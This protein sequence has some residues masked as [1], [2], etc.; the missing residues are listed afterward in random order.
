[1]EEEY[2]SI[3]PE[4]PMSV[5]SVVYYR[6]VSMTITKRDSTIKIKP[7]IESQ[8]EMIDWA[9]DQKDCKPSWNEETNK[10]YQQSEKSPTASRMHYKPQGGLSQEDCPHEYIDK[11]Q[12]TGMSK[13]ENKGRWYKVCSDC[14]KFLGWI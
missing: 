12:S 6:G 7:L 4:A 1:M 13:P 5:S 11:R 3:L 8:M 10:Q 9:L 14:K 2:E